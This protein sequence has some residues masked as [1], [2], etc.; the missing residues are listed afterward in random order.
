MVI[1]RQHV[2]DWSVRFLTHFF[3]AKR[4][5][6]ERLA[7]IDH[8]GN[9]KT[10]YRE[11]V[12]V[13]NAFGAELLERGIKPGQVVA[14]DLGRVMEHHAARIACFAVG[15]VFVSLSPALP[16]ARRATI[17]EDSGASLLIDDNFV[18]RALSAHQDAP[19]CLNI[20]LRD[21]DPGFIVF[22][23]GTTGKPKG[24]LHDRTI[25]CM[26]ACV[27]RDIYAKGLG[28][29]RLPLERVFFDVIGA[30][31]Y[32]HAALCDP[33]VVMSMFDTLETFGV[34]VHLIDPALLRDAAGLVGY[35]KMN[36]IN[37]T[38]AV[39]GLLN[40]LAPHIT[41][42]CVVIAGDMN[43]FDFSKLEHTY[44]ANVYGASECP[45]MGLGRRAAKQPGAPASARQHL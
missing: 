37:T 13:V 8:Q 32:T 39:P 41:F 31:H 44:V 34:T 17:L 29:E 16:E 27:L 11:Y 3:N 30:G 23:S 24:M 5:F 26:L 4:S 42:D 20:N 33:T 43:R 35:L 1:R 12:S 40:A 7:V 9:R 6:P 25:F 15:A 38:I 36:Q 21:T 2:D 28:I 22:T 19:E 10:T 45:I 18:A 14:I